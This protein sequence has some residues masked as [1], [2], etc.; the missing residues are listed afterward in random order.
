MTKYSSFT[1][2]ETPQSEPIP[3]KDQVLNNA[4][5]YV[6]KLDQ[7]KRL[8]R[9]LILGSDSSTY[10]QTEKALTR[11][12][13]LGVIQC[14]ADDPER[15]ANTIVGI[16]LAG[17]APRVS[18]VIFALALGAISDNVE[19]RRAAYH[20]VQEVC[21]TAS[22]LFE[23]MAYCAQLGKGGGRGFKN[24]VAAWY[25]NRDTDALAY[26]MI[27][28]RER[29]GFNHKRAIE[30]GHKG[31]GEDAPRAALYRWARGKAFDENALPQFVKAHR[32]AMAMAPQAE[33]EKL[34]TK[35]LVTLVADYKLPWEAIPNQALREPAI[36]EAMQPH[37][38]LTAL[39]RNLG[40]MTE[41]GAIGPQKTKPVVKRLSDAAALKKARIH[42]FNVLQALAVYKAG[43]GFRGSKTWT[44]ED[45]V[46]DALDGAFY[47]A[48]ANVE[49]TGKRIYIGLD[50]SGSM[51]VPMMGSPLTCREASAALALVTV[52]TEPE[53]MVYG[54]S[55]VGR[56]SR[57]DT[58]ITAM[59]KLDISPKRRLD[60]IV[61]SI[62]NLPFGG[63]DCALPMLHALEEGLQVD[64]FV[65]L[66]DN[67][68]WAGAIHPVEALRKYR[69]K[70]GIPAKLIV[71]GMTSTA[72]SIADPADG[73]MLD[74]VGF[75]S[76]GPAL[77]GDFIK[78]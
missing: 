34:N 15:T 18:P 39:I 33:E 13:A 8:E 38:G 49:A 59:T 30:L 14:W 56:Y 66:T 24:V 68:T 1:Q 43:K 20:S 22:H 35:G 9:F 75:D 4:G 72:F 74:I 25:N 51:G 10:Y 17:R 63:T 62:S 29:N 23:W 3:G 69:Q 60:D 11:E 27:K 12:N 41:V 71:V 67:E 19:A 61:K 21:R 45:K 44:P 32:A 2:S 37:L 50:I 57:A 47:A 28:F 26:Q 64:A 65:I 6:F 55:S 36:W 42:P 53:T 77:I 78:N 70:T 40:N 7:W 76:N 58:A 16:S 5:G 52:A 54:F 31:A 48:F 46:C 73:G